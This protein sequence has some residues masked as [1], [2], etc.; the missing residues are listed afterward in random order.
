[1]CSWNKIRFLFKRTFYV[2]NISG[3]FTNPF[4]PGSTFYLS[5]QFMTSIFLGVKVILFHFLC[6]PYEG[7]YYQSDKNL[8]LTV[9][10]NISIFVPNTIAKNLTVCLY[11]H[12]MHSKHLEA[13]VLIYFKFIAQ[14]VSIH[15]YIIH[16]YKIFFYIKIFLYI[17]QFL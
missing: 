10:L 3:L 9:W 1:M 5:S 12:F 16:F 11:V 15:H 14:S 4:M 17:K 7:G 2:F 8:N 13:S 6:H